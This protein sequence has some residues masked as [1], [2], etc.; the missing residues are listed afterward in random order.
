MIYVYSIFPG[1][2]WDFSVRHFLTIIKHPF[3]FIAT[4]VT[5]VISR[6]IKGLEKFVCSRS[7]N[8]HGK[9]QPA[10]TYLD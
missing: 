10:V 2:H 6:V 4:V 5:D 3:Y 9:D 1:L 7:I 8:G